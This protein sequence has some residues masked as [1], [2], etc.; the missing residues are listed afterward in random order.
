MI[1]EG[2]SSAKGRRHGKRSSYLKMSQL[3]QDNLADLRRRRQSELS[4]WATSHNASIRVNMNTQI[5]HFYKEQ[6][7]VLDRIKRGQEM[8]YKAYVRVNEQKERIAKTKQTNKQLLD[9]HEKKLL[10]EGSKTG[11]HVIKG[12]KYRR[13]GRT[14]DKLPPIAEMMDAK[15]SEH[16]GSK[17][18]DVNHH[19]TENH[20]DKS[21]LEHSHH[22]EKSFYVKTGYGSK[23]R[24]VMYGKEKTKLSSNL[25]KPK[26]VKDVSNNYT[27]QAGAIALSN[28]S[29]HQVS[30]KND[31]KKSAKNL[32]NSSSHQVAAKRDKNSTSHHGATQNVSNDSAHQVAAKSENST[33]HQVAPRNVSN[34]SAHQVAAKSDEN[35]ASHQV[36]PRNVSNNSAHRGAAKV[37]EVSKDPE[38]PKTKMRR[39]ERSRKANLILTIDAAKDELAKRKPKKLAPIEPKQKS[40]STHDAIYD[41]LQFRNQMH[42][43]DAINIVSKANVDMDLYQIEHVD[44]RPLMAR[45]EKAK[46]EFERREAKKLRLAAQKAEDEATALHL[47]AQNSTSHDNRTIS[48]TPRRQEIREIKENAVLPKINLKPPMLPK[49]PKAKK[50]KGSLTELTKKYNKLKEKRQREILDSERVNC[51]RKDD[52]GELVPMLLPVKRQTFKLPTT[53]HQELQKQLIKEEKENTKRHRALMDKFIEEIGQEGKLLQLLYVY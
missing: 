5:K 33:S 6:N 43:S 16:L 7:T 36:A 39:S 9:E 13:K 1:R 20:K 15:S 42:A 17:D 12:N 31:S 2:V 52:K 45:A 4:Q 38:A 32:N 46:L 30:A 27:H 26:L 19:D 35:S 53:R 29:A 10:W 22:G 51:Y 18:K 28:D 23:E 8:A 34:N 3:G 49:L 21:R 24:K 11:S 25:R 44:L 37:L 47:Q 41:L 14:V 48:L 40:L 50:D